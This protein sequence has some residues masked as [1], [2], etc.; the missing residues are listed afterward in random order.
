MS[1][2]IDKKISAGIL[3]LTLSISLILA[4]FCMAAILL[5]YYSNLLWIQAK[6]SYRVE[7]NAQSALEYVLNN[8]ISSIPLNSSFSTDLFHQ[9]R[10]SV[11]ISKRAWGIYNLLSIEA[12]SNKIRHNTNQLIGYA[13]VQNNLALYVCNSSPTALTLAGATEINGNAWLPSKGIKAGTYNRIGY[14]GSSLVAGETYRS[15]SKLPTLDDN[16]NPKLQQVYDLLGTKI[17]QVKEVPKAMENSFHNQMKILYSQESILLQSQL[18][19]NIAVVSASEIEI[20]PSSNLDNIILV[21][22][23][24]KFKPGFKGCVQAFA[25]KFINLAS[26]VKLLYPSALITNSTKDSQINISENV[27]FQGVIYQSGDTKLNPSIFISSG[28]RIEGQ[29]ITHGSIEHHGI[30][31]G[32]ILCNS[33]E[34]NDNSGLHINYLFNAVVDRFSLPETYLFPG[35][36]ASDIQ[37]PEIITRL[38]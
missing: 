30:V 17:E 8:K 37:Y 31:Y 33:F 25:D 5:A 38:Q 2:I 20:D 14:S 34:I 35:I 12:Y 1:K 16:I 24:I 13:G 21:A 3:P 6:N 29:V 10:D 19:G 15:E 11:T 32:Q 18:K 9:G 28:S 7:L 36:L 4:L 22:P 27:V 26:G 23:A